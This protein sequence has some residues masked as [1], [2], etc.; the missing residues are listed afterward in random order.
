MMTDEQ[1]IDA[2]FTTEPCGYEKTPGFRAFLLDAMAAIGERPRAGDVASM[3]M[4]YRAGMESAPNW[5]T[6]RPTKPGE[7]WLSI[8]PSKRGAWAPVYVAEIYQGQRWYV[9]GK[10]DAP[11]SDD[12]VL[13]VGDDDNNDQLPNPWR[14]KRF[15]DD[16]LFDGAQWAERATP[17]DPFAN[18]ISRVERVVR[19]GQDLDHSVKYRTD[20]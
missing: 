17:D 15:L 11:D 6:D 3:H 5:T 7:Y 9:D 1:Y 16:S 2:L 13:Y 14:T 8:H 4:A 18:L 20:L 19:A 12:Y 10:W